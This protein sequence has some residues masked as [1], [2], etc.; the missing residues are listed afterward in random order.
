[1][2]NKDLEQFV[3]TL[4]PFI[5]DKLKKDGYLKNVVKVQ[6]AIV[7]SLGENNTVNVKFPYDTK[8]FSALNES[9]EELNIGD[10]VRIRYWI[11]LKNAI[12]ERKLR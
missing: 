11:D 2:K 5:L 6:N 12:V 9:G 1:M 8:T 4:Y 10:G 7:D 3:E